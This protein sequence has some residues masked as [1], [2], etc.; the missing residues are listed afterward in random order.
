M[1]KKKEEGKQEKHEEG[2]SYETAAKVQLGTPPFKD[3]KSPN[4]PTNPQLLH[5]PADFGC[6]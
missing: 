6:M 4:L 5:N 2:G 1:K 3:H